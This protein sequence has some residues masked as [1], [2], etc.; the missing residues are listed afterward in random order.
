MENKEL[1]LA[2]QIIANTGT[3]LFLTGKAGTGKTTFLRELRDRLPKRMV[4]VAP[5]GIAAINAQGVT[6]HSFFQLSFGPQI[7][8]TQHAQNKKYKFRKQKLRLIKSIDLI[9]IDEISMVRADVL[10]A[11]D[12]V[13]RQYRD[14][15]QPFGG[16]QMLMIGDMQQLP[17]VA[18]EEEWRLLAPYY[19]TPYFFSSKVLQQADFVTVE[20][21]KVYRQSDQV[22]L[23]LLNKVR[24]NIADDNTLTALN[25]RYIPDFMPNKKDGYIRLTT[26]NYQADAINKRELDALNTTTHEFKA[27]VNGDFPEAS[28]PTEQM[29]TLKQ[30]AQ[31]MFVK[32]DS[33]PKKQY[34]NGMIGEVVDFDEESIVVRTIDD[35]SIIYVGHETWENTRYDLDPKTKEI[36]EEVIGTFAQYPLKTAWAITVHKSQGLT[37]EHAILD[38]QHS[39]AHGQTYVALSR[40]KSLEG[41]VLSNPIPRAAIINDSQVSDFNHD[42]R[43]QQPDEHRLDMMERHYLLHI[44]EDLFTFVQIRY[45]INDLIRLMREHFYNSHP[46]L[47][48]QWLEAAEK[49]KEVEKVAWRFHNQ[50]ENLVMTMPDFRTNALLQERI[51]KGANYFAENILFIGNLLQKTNL[52]TE[53]KQ[54]KERLE[55][56]MQTFTDA[57]KV[58]FQLLHYVG[59]NGLTLQKYLEEKAKINISLDESKDKS[60]KGQKEDIKNWAKYYA[61]KKNSGKSDR[62]A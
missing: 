18:K 48:T 50:Y 28:F 6:I 13:L 34:Y 30:G 2:W 3:H 22:F 56:L 9:V 53:N 62:K 7:P 42:P 20:L 60:P 1:Q 27:E 24:T 12:S 35:D 40:C 15:N 31:V 58:K 54:V 33:S 11:I 19:Q 37:F 32:N 59:N 8:G 17:P 55:N 51:T 16:V 43:H 45:S 61:I 10:D 23:E 21:Q 47:Y 4:V 36:T 38:V 25:K 52:T 5:T 46:K 29:L 14:R 41:M 39:F 26:H 49:F 44:I 57:Y